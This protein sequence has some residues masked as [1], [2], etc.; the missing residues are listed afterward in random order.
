MIVNR[1][2]FYWSIIASL[3]VVPGLW[4]WALAQGPE[5][6][7]IPSV[8]VEEVGT[9]TTSQP[10]RYV[11][12][13]AAKETVAVV[14]R[15]SG[16]LEKIAFQEGSTIKKGDLLFEIENTI[17]A[18]NVKVAESVIRQIE[19]EIGLAQRELERITTL[20]AR[21]VV[22]DR[23]LDEASRTRE[24]HQAKLEEAKAKLALAQNDLSYTKIYA[25]LTG[26]I[27]AKQFSEG[28]YITP[29]SGTLASIVQYD[30]ITVKI[31]L[32]EMDFMRFFQG[33]CEEG[34]NACIEIFRA[35]GLPY[36]GEFKVDFFDNRVDHETGTLTTYL[37][38][39]NETGQ[40]LPGGFTEVRLAEKFAQPFP[41]VN[42]AAVMTNGVHHYV[43]VLVEGNKIERRE[44]ELGPQVF[45]QYAITSG[46]TPGEKVVVGGA[47]KVMPGQ[48]VNPHQ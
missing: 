11:G 40:L 36:Q 46:L 32:S 30:P 31:M 4:K 37:I 7:S 5:K 39:Q 6:K 21:Q 1:R 13:V 17:Y 35:D 23:E 45:S 3:L 10:K 24:L 41:A 8:R 38:C 29:T 16:F 27:G 20:H 44:V 42:V 25:P 33:N 43:F 28:N 26:R 12:Y 15:I 14:P 48:E 47:N 22:T 2:L 18:M 34:T 19:A 9:L